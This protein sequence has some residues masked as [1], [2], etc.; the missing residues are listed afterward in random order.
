LIGELDIEISHRG[1]HLGYLGQDVA[2]SLGINWGLLPRKVG[3]YVNYLGGGL[4]GSVCTGGYSEKITGK[5]KELLDELLAACARAYM[6][7]EN[8]CGLN[9]DKYPDGE[10]N[11]EAQGTKAMRAAGVKTYPGL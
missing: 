11:W 8:D 2:Q 4:R 7:A 6:N 10:T 3:A 5:K 9:D 1:G